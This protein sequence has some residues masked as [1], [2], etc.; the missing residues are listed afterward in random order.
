MRGLGPTLDQASKGDTHE[1]GAGMGSQEGGCY[2]SGEKVRQV[3]RDGAETKQG[4]N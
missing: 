4:K 3:S 1:E 2:E